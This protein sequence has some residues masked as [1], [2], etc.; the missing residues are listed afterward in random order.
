MPILFDQNQQIFH[1]QTNATSYVIQLVHGLH[2][3]HVYWG[4]RLR[5]PSV[6][7]LLHR[8]ERCSFSPNYYAE[9]RTFSFDTLPQEYPGYGRGD[10]REPAVEIALSNGS[11]V[12]DLHYVSHRITLGKPK[13]EGLPATYVEHNSEADTLEIVLQDELT[14]VEAVLQYSVFNELNAI[15][16]SV[17]LRN[18]GTATVS[19]ERALS[20]SV[21]FGADQFEMLH[22]SGAWVR[23]RHMHYRKLAP[24]LQ[25]VESKRGS[26]SH[27][28]NPFIALLEKGADEQHGGVYGMSL[29]YSGNFVAQVEVEQ[30][31]TTRMQIGLSPFDFSWQLAPGESFQTPEAVLV[32]SAHGLGALSRTYHR[33]YRTRLSRGEHRDNV[34]PI[35]INNW[36][37]T[38]FDFDAPKIKQIA[39]AGKELGIELFVLDDGWFGH[40][41]DDRS[42]LG[43]WV[44]DRRKLPEGLSKLAQHIVDTGMQ[45]GLWFEPEMISPDSDLYRAHP[46]WCLH[47]PDRSRTMGREQLIL[48]LSRADVCDYIVDSISKVLS[49]A[50]ITYVKWDMNRN[51]TEIGS[52]LLPGERQRETAHRYMLGLYNVLE[53]IT[54]AFPHVLFESCSGGGGRF[55]P[56][57]LHYMPQTWTS[58]D[59]DAVE[60]LKIQYGTSVVYPASA[61]GSH[62]SAVPNHQVGRITSFATRGHVAMSGN[63]G[64]ELDLTRLTDEE[65]QEVRE[66][67]KQ[68]KQLRELIQFGEFYRL[69]SPFAGNETAWMFVSGDQSE[70][71]AG[72]F[73][74]LAEPNPSLRR[75][76]LQGLDPERPYRMSVNGVAEGLYYGDELMYHGI[77]LAER[78]G[79]FQSTLFSFRAE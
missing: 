56:G 35:L 5:Q 12:S 73:K 57:M 18:G 11:T 54:T 55:D 76:K 50:P 17:R 43:D 65:K 20:S 46:D 32:Y 27:Q 75:L 16:R 38:Y 45:F 69:L 6:S 61:M 53:R 37:A 4:P 52:A 71:F 51:M 13:L 74:V 79:D 28:H 62:V 39:A 41:D 23:E 9:D 48:D 42:S 58:D 25:R 8:I 77:A 47:V 59:T 30:F 70:A 60:R 49:S 10:Y 78:Y 19:I 2:P 21:D 66:Q 67:V 40:R 44:E 68:Y 64:Y 72:Y 36:E 24:G 7:S 3:A 1:L 33:L 15:S 26:S 34:R 29:V 14:G 22:L 63:F 31:G